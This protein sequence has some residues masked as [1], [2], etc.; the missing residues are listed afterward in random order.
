M[1]APTTMKA[2]VAVEGKT[3]KVASNVAV[4]KLEKGEVLI[5]VEAL[6]LNPTE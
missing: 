1:S 4:P 2:V 5:K 6:T 3:V